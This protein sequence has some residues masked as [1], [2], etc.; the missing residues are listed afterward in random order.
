ML[1]LEFL[2]DGK[3]SH[4]YG[5]FRTD[6]P[7]GDHWIIAFKTEKQVTVH[8]WDSDLAAKPGALHLCSLRCFASDFDKFFSPPAPPEEATDAQQ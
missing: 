5:P 4:A 7:A 6:D 3:E 8:K 1:K 2:C